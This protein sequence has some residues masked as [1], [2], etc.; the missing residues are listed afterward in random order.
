MK[1]KEK[2]KKYYSV[3]IIIVG[4]QSVGKTNIALRFVHGKFA[5]TNYTI[6]CV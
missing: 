6:F 1:N 3:K 2:E 4:N 5:R